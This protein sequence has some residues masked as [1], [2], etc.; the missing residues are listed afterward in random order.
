MKKL[1]AVASAAVLV[2]VMAVPA[3]GGAAVP[4]KGTY[5]A[6]DFDEEFVSSLPI[7]GVP[8][9][10]VTIQFDT[11]LGPVTETLE[12]PESSFVFHSNGG[13]HFRGPATWDFGNGDILYTMATG[14]I[15]FGSGNVTVNEDVISGEGLYAG[16]TGT[17]HNTQFGHEQSAFPQFGGFIVGVILLR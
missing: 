17:I 16:A 8:G 4:F 14:V 9:L 11:N 12:V 15:S 7:L 10:L 1:I 5:D 2:F 13:L 6:E 3:V